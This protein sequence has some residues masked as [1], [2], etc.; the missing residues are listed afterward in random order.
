MAQGHATTRFTPFRVL[1]L[2]SLKKYKGVMQFIQCAAGL[3]EIQFDLVLN[4]N[5]SDIEQFFQHQW[6]PQNLQ[7]Y[8][9]QFDVHPFYEKASLVMNLSVPDQWVETFGMTALE[10]MVYGKPVIVPPVGGIV[11][12]VEN[13]VSGYCLDA[14]NTPAIME[15]IMGL[16]RDP[17][18]YD[19]MSQEA[20]A[21][22]GQFTQG[23]FRKAILDCIRQEMTATHPNEVSLANV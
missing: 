4:A 8:P 5:L 23:G 14:R 3:P 20:L 10:G 2:C 21:R 18:L 7:D 13:G 12:L 1:M 17:D 11:E 9:A 15:K 16:S 6:L 19:R 22:A